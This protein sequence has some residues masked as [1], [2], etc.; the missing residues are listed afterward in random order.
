MKDRTSEIKELL[1]LKEM[2]VAHVDA[3]S[4]A[5]NKGCKPHQSIMG[6]TS[7]EYRSTEEYKQ[8]CREYQAA[9]Q[10]LEAFWKLVRGNKEFAKANRERAIAYR[11]RNVTV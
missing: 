3:A 8:L 9:K 2:L 11:F 5:L 10:L 4:T 7:D 1:E 6:L